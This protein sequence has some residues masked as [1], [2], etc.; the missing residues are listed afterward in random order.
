M[1]SIHLQPPSPL[2]AFITCSVK[3]ERQQALI[4]HIARFLAAD[5]QTPLCLSVMFASPPVQ[6][7]SSR[8]LDVLKLIAEGHSNPEIAKQL[9]LSPNTV[10]THVRNLL[11]K[12]GVARRTQLVAIAMTFEPSGNFPTPKNKSIGSHSVP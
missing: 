4:D 5:P 6:R 7:P 3:A 11:N 12:F 9:H 10:K 1:T 2:T 8:E